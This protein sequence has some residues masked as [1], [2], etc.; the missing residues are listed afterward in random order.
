MTDGKG[1]FNVLESVKTHIDSLKPLQ[2]KQAIVCI[3]EYPIK[4]LLKQLN[5]KTQ[6][7]IAIFVDKSSEEIYQWIPKGYNPHFVLGFEDA[8]VNT[9]FWYNVLPYI[10]QN[11]S[12]VESLSQKPIEKLRGVV[13]VAS[14]WDGVGS[15]SLPTLISKFKETNKNA[16]SLAILPSKIQPSDA[17]FNA[18]AAL[19]NCVSI[20]D[21][22]ILLLDRDCLE[23][24]EGVDRSGAQMKGNLIVNY[25]VDLLLS[26][27]SLA[28]EVTELSRTFN[29]KMFAALLASGASMKIYGSLE[30]I[31]EAALLKPL[32][33]FDLPSAGLLYVLIRMPESLKDK[34]PRGKIELAIATWF[35]EKANLKSI[36]ITEPVYTEDTSDRI[37]VALLIGGFDTSKMF[38]EYEMKTKSLKASAIKK[39]A[40]KEEEWQAMTKNLLEGA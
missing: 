10:S 9:H 22:T 5:S 23:N 40:I 17:Y 37:D 24:F 4:L 21:S 2:P 33:N 15:A 25:L 1:A 38:S 7:T 12:I 28:D 3:G 19:G 13:I 27:E 34:L 30:N 8:N 39:G 20:D 26:K 29:T 16:L 35:K 36:Y 6:E 18:F 32:L 11:Q 31:F 14:V